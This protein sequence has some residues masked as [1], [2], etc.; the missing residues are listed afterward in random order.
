MLLRI[1]MACNVSGD[2]SPYT[3]PD[4]L[5]ADVNL[6]KIMLYIDA[7]DADINLCEELIP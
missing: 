6:D 3:M 5:M 7:A 4:P 1:L 2:C